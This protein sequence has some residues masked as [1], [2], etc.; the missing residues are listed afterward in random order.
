ME[1]WEFALMPTQAI[2][3]RGVT[4]PNLKLMEHKIFIPFIFK[5][6]YLNTEGM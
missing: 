4:Y 5:P 3:N 2:G 6:I 1:D